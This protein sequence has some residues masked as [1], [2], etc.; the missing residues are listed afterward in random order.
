MKESTIPIGRIAGVRI[1]INWTWLAIF[2]L[3]LWLLAT[4]VLPEEHPDLSAGAHWGLAG[5]ATVVFFASLL[6]HELGH[7]V[8]GRRDGVEVVGITLWLFGALTRFRGVYPS[9][10]AELRIALAGPLVSALVAGGLIALAALAPL[11]DSLAWTLRWLGY[12]NAIMLACNLLPLRA[13]DGG[14]IL[15]GVLWR[16]T[17]DVVWATQR[18]AAIGRGLAYVLIGG[19]V[20]FV[21]IVLL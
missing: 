10:G 15:H 14:R 8:Q 7:A 20:L 12:V 1:G 17:D 4:V 19:L 5:V 2:A 11:S 13:L 3:V 9:A 21:L 16:T 18:S 6:A